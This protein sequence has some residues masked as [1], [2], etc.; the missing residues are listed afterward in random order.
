MRR[1]VCRFGVYCCSVGLLSILAAVVLGRDVLPLV[2]WA[3]IFYPVLVLAW[4]FARSSER[5]RPTEHQ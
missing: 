2:A 5:F 4:W 3:I 1:E